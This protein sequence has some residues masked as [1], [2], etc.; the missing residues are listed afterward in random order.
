VQH[1]GDELY[2]LGHTLGQF[3]HLLVP[4][5]L[6]TELHEPLLQFGHGLLTAES[7]E[8]CQIESLLPYLHLLVQS[9]FL[10]QVADA[11]DIVRN[12]RIAVEEDDSGVGHRNLIHNADE[13]GLARAVGAQQ[14]EDSPFWDLYRDM[15]KGGIGTER[16]DYVPTGD[17]VHV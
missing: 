4:P 8:A 7:L 10:G 6:D 16:L 3:L 13:S 15:V 14:T 12:D 1:G 17:S 9:P 5:A 2:F 11:V